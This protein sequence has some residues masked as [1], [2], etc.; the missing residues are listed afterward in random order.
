MK[1]FGLVLACLLACGALAASVSAAPGLKL[2][3]QDIG[4]KQCNAG[5]KLVVDVHFKIL[6]DADSGFGGNYW[7]NDN[8]DRHLRIW[9][10]GPTAFCAQVEDHGKFV[11]YAGTSPGGAGTVSAGITG[12]IEGGYIAQITGTFAPP[13]DLATRGDLGTFDMGCDPLGNCSGSRPSFLSYFSGSPAWTQP[14]WGWIYHAGKNGTW[15]NQ[16][17]VAAADSGD[18][19]G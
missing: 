3:K 11:T 18:I 12:N 9:Q 8:L 1:K 10:Q 7:A 17:D 2:D 16:D 4:P 19:T 14:Q 13:S 5:A 6:N 15:L